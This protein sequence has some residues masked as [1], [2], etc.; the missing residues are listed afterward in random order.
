[1]GRKTQNSG[2]AAVI[3]AAGMSRRMKSPEAM[4]KQLLP[5][6]GRPLL[7]HTVDNVGRSGVDEI[8]LVLGFAAD[9]VIRQISA[10]G[11]RV[12]VNQEFAQGMGT[13]LRAGIAA[14]G[15]HVKAA[16]AV[17]ADQPLVRP[18][19]LDRLIAYHSESG[20]QITIPLYK[21]F[22]GNPV[23]LDRSVFSEV[24]GLSGDVGCRAIFGS[25]TQGIHKLDAGDPG[26]LLDIDS[27]ED[28]E[29]LTQPQ[30]AA[31]LAA[32]PDLES[33]EGAAPERPELVIVGRDAVARALAKLAKV[34]GLAVIFVD[35]FL[36]LKDTPEADA[37]LHVMDFSQLTPQKER[38]VVVASRGQFDEE[39]VEQAVRS[40]A[41]YVALL[42]NRKRASEIVSSLQAKGLPEEQLANVRAPAGLE[43]GAESP[44]EIALSILAEIVKERKRGV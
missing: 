20:A 37:V 17:L 8:V 39:G 40:G 3:L 1:M 27:F 42:A 36:G 11:A 29:K 7:Q 15:P 25:H 34:L 28:F 24:M 13:S 31:E 22:R 10:E 21:G 4:P 32:L 44:E 16:F 14:L 41:N 26:I 12:I 18:E 43:I 9:S 19:T 5:L 23:L 33:R 6:A 38:Y 30:L 2:V 35:P